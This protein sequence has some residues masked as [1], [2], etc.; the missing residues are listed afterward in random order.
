MFNALCRLALIFFI[1]SVIIPFFFNVFV[2]C[3][4][5]SSSM[6]CR[7]CERKAFSPCASTQL[8][9]SFCHSCDNKFYN[10]PRRKTF[11]LCVR[12]QLLVF[13]LWLCIL[14]FVWQSFQDLLTIKL[15]LDQTRLL[16]FF[17]LPVDSP[18]ASWNYHLRDLQCFRET[19]KLR[20]QSRHFIPR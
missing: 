1:N 17:S 6:P 19:I 20:R 15:N 14:S 18:V 8:H 2:C 13:A 12:M 9:V 4:T 11:C 7:D 16:H 3:K 5:P 10:S